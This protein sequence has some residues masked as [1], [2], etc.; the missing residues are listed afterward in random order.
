MNVARRNLLDRLLVGA[1][2]LADAVVDGLRHDQAGR[3]P[4]P[5]PDDAGRALARR[6]AQRLM[7]SGPRLSDTGSHETRED[8]V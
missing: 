8:G 6:R 4:T 5:T 3:A 1:V 2:R 7:G